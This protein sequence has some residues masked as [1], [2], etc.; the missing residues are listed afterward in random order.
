MSASTSTSAAIQRQHDRGLFGFAV[1]LLSESMVFLSLF[2][3]Y[4]ALRLTSEHWL[5]AGVSGLE[6]TKPAINT[7][8]LLASSGVIVLAE[9][10]LKHHH[11][12]RFRLFLLLTFGMGSYFLWG[13]AQEWQRLNFSITTGLFGATFYLLT[14]FHGL[15]VLTGLILQS[16]MG[17]RSYRPGNYRG[18][19]WG[20]SATALFWHFV[21][22][23]WVVLF[24]L[25][26]LWQP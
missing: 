4:L 3:A 21:D 24:S 20:V 8:V 9:R 6:L 23:I 1:F 11:L 5:P 25:L 19:H 10:S 16:I 2:M 18:G 7:A 22:G 14:G 26:Y 17:I 12:R 15:H 13:Q